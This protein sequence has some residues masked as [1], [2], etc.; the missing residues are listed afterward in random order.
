MRPGVL[1]FL[2]AAS[3]AL[4]VRRLTQLEPGIVWGEG[5]GSSA[6]FLKL[7][8]AGITEADVKS[9]AVKYAPDFRVLCEVNGGGR[10]MSELGMLHAV[11]TSDLEISLHHMQKLRFLL[12]ALFRAASEDEGSG[13]P[14]G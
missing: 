7:L 10:V 6:A 5:E 2:C 13:G 3:S 1:F 8:Y 9:L 4:P 11:R 14:S 12:H